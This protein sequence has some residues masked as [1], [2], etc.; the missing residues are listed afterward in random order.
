LGFRQS[1]R[2]LVCSRSGVLG[3]SLRGGSLRFGRGGFRFGRGGFCLCCGSGGV[4]CRRIWLVIA[5]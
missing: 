3:L 4:G 1:R 5:A 2:S